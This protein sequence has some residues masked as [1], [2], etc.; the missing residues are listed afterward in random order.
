MAFAGG[1]AAAGSRITADTLPPDASP[2]RTAL[3]AAYFDCNESHVISGTGH[4]VPRLFPKSSSCN[5]LQ[6]R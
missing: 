1:P 2:A 5:R 4:Y 3:P 6:Y